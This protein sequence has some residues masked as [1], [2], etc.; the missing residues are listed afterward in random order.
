M[1]DGQLIA[2]KH[3]VEIRKDNEKQGDISDG[4]EILPVV[5]LCDALISPYKQNRSRSALNNKE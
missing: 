5:D 4:S 1:L 3:H 2:E